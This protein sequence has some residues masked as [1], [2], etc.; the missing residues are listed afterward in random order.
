MA[1]AMLGIIG[2]SGLGDAL[3]GPS[4]GDR[5][6]VQTPFGDPS[7]EIILTDEFGEG[8]AKP[9]PRAFELMSKRLAV[10]PARCVYVADNPAKDFLAPN[11]LGWLT[12]QWRRTGQVHAHKPAPTGGSPQRIVRSGPGLLR[13]LTGTQ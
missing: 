8:Y 11:A 3:C 13:L 5:R 2:G 12:V 1:E 10:E 6:R 9:H 7:D 4:D